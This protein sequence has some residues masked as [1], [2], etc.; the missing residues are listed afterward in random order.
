MSALEDCCGAGRYANAQ[1]APGGFCEN[2]SCNCAR[3]ATVRQKYRY[4]CGRSGR[5]YVFSIYSPQDCP[6]YDDA[7]LIVARRGEGGEALALIETGCFPDADLVEMRRR[8]RSRLGELEFQIHV[9][10]DRRG[11]RRLLIEDL[12]NARLDA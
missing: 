5:S 12:T 2:Q 1:G 7:V 3:E 4:W 8:F 11:D 10:T 6:A 9:L